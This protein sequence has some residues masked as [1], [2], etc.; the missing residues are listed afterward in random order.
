[1]SSAFS[2]PSTQTNIQTARVTVR[3]ATRSELQQCAAWKHAF[4]H[5]HKDHRYYEIVEDTILQGFDYRYFVLE[6][7]EDGLRAIQPFFVLDQDLL[8]G[9]GAWVRGIFGVIRKV[10][11]RFLKMRTLMVG[12]AAGEGH[13]ESSEEEEGGW[14]AGA[15]C[16]EIGEVARTY[17]ASLI[18]FKEF[19]SGYR[20]AMACLVAKG[21][22]R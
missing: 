22:T 7:A 19:A 12:C 1:M 10:F 16:A 8:Q 18:V 15:L 5:L 9:A 4:A 20:K 17:R 3:V 21:Y 14:I 2:A 11:P 6:D 13:L